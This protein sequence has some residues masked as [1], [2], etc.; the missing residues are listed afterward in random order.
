M[1]KISIKSAKSRIL[2]G[3]L[4]HTIIFPALYAEWMI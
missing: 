1:K 2:T 4:A 3:D